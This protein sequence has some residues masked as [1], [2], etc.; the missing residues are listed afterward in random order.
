MLAYL[1]FFTALRIGPIAVVSPVV[2][3]FGGLTVVLAVVFRGETPDDP[4]G[5]W[6]RACH[7]PGIVMTG[8]VL[9]RRI[10]SI[11][12]RGA[13]VAFGLIALT[14]L[15]DPGTVGPADRSGES[16]LAPGRSSYRGASM[17]RC[18]VG[19][20][21]RRP[22]ARPR[23]VAIDG[24][25]PV[26]SRDRRGPAWRSCAAGLLDVTGPHLV[27]D[28]PRGRRDLARRDSPRPSVPPWPRCLRG[29]LPGRAPSADPV[30]RPAVLGAGMLAITV[31]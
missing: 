18:F 26:A 5:R 11:R 27:R 14:P 16:R 2:A 24:R 25:R 20:P 10:R 13:G 3:A 21:R 22:V 30:D 28:R 8:V 1:T 7:D 31:G 29:R 4:P 17:S 12:L 19:V 15:R 23:C 9:G 6:C